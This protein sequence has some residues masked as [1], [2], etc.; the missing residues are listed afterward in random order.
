M[1]ITVD[2]VGKM[3]RIEKWEE[4]NILVQGKPLKPAP[5]TGAVRFTGHLEG[6]KPW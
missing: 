2:E 3:E 4:V 1:E 5:I 6:K